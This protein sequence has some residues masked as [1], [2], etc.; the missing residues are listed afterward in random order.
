MHGHDDSQPCGLNCPVGGADG[1]LHQATIE[2]IT[3]CTVQPFT[4]EEQTALGAYFRML[5]KARDRRAGI[6]D[7]DSSS[8]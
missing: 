2:G 8:P 7:L 5:R 3:L 1:T 4:D 6:Q